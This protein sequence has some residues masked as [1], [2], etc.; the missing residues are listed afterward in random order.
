MA[1]YIY[2]F[3]EFLPPAAVVRVPSHERLQRPAHQQTRVPGTIFQRFFPQ[4]IADFR[5]VYF[6]DNCKH[7]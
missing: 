5:V 6:V 4:N 7:L 3:Q 1:V 2:I